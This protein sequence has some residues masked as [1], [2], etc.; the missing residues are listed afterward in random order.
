[1]TGIEQADIER[2]LTAEEI[3]V[4]I[5]MANFRRDIREARQSREWRIV[6]LI[7]AA[8]GGLIL[9]ANRIPPWIVAPIAVL[10]LAFHWWILRWN[11][12]RAEHDSRKMW[13][14]IEKVERQFNPRTE[15]FPAARFWSHAPNL[16]Q[17]LT[18][19]A[20]GIA[21]IGAHW[22]GPA[23]EASKSAAIVV[24]QRVPP[25]GEPTV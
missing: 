17:L 9:Q 1:M 12:Q 6:F 2:Q 25:G 14:W 13:W 23:G 22:I 5:Q 10:I 3:G 11:F 21:A 16:T 7:W 8:L 15:P 4:C 24:S 18:T 20:L 19:A